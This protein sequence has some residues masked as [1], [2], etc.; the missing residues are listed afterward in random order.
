MI[1]T[2]SY[3]ANH[4]EVFIIT[5]KTSDNKTLSLNTSLVYDHLA[6]GETFNST[7]YKIAAGVGLLSRNIKVIGAEYGSQ[8][9]DLYGLRTIVSDYSALDADSGLILYY[10]GYARISD[11]E[12]VHPGQF[13]RNTDDDSKFGILFSNLGAYNTVRPSY[14]KNSAFHHGFGTAVGIYGSSSIPIL[15]NVV[16]YTIDIALD[17]KG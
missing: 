11:A 1:T 14:V 12:F 13:S 7:S 6:F 2:T 8:A 5:G 10:K 15:N 17:I 3:F 16:Y 4:S 9:A